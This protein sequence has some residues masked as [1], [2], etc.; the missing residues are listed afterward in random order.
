M[1]S[2]FSRL[3]ALAEEFMMQI[4]IGKDEFFSRERLPTWG[5]RGTKLKSVFT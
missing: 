5:S 2:T 3:Y 4:E 1:Y